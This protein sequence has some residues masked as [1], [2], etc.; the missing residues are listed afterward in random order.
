MREVDARAARMYVELMDRAGLDTDQ[1]I[2]GL[3]FDRETIRDRGVDWADVTTLFDRLQDACGGPDG[4]ADLFSDFA[5]T[6]TGKAIASLTAL[7]VEPQTFYRFLNTRL[8][9]S[10]YTVFRSSHEDLPGAYRLTIEIVAGKTPS[11]PFMH[12]SL[13][14]CRGQPR[15]F[16]LPKTSVQADITPRKG[17]FVVAVADGEPLAR[18]ARRL[19]DSLAEVR[20]DLERAYDDKRR[21]LAELRDVRDLSPRAL[22]GELS[23]RLEA[24]GVECGLTPRERAVL[25]ELAPGKSNK[26]IATKLG[27][28]AATVE[29]HLTNLLRKTETRNR[30]EL[31]AKLWAAG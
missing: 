11:A 4:M 28:A 6:A 26:E 25:R 19:V 7:F 16:G 23:Q 27:C 5:V 22:P 13:G 9:A 18:R 12:A 30:T 24:L 2:D 21:V 14:A 20:R 15:L 17:T 3:G 31:V 29:V 8:A 1:I 10:S